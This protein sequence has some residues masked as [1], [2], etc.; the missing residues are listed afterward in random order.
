[1]Q[2]EPE[3]SP[4][5]CPLLGGAPSQRAISAIECS[6]LRLVEDLPSAALLFDD[7]NRVLYCNRAAKV[8]AQMLS[9]EG[10]AGNRL[11]LQDWHPHLPPEHA[12][13][14]CRERG[15]WSGEVVLD[16]PARPARVILL[17]VTALGPELSAPYGAAFRDVTV[18]AGRE[19]ELNLRNAELEIAMAKLGSAQ[20]QVLRTEKLASIGQLAA[21]VAH[22]INNPIAYVKSNLNTLQ[23][24][25]QRLLGALRGG[26][27]TARGGAGG[28]AIDIDEIAAD[29]RDL[30]AE[31][32]E[33]VERVC[34]IV[35]DL[36]DFSHQ[37]TGD[38]WV[39]ADIHAT[40]ESTLNV[41][42]NEIKYKAHV[43]KTFGDLPAIECLPSE[44]S[45]VFMNLL[46]NAAQAMESYG[47]ITLSTE[48][49]GDRVRVSIGDDGKGI[50]ADVL[51]RIFDP[52]FTTKS[53][54]EGTGLG[55]AISY[56]VV[57]KHHGTINVTSEPGQGTL[58]MIELPIQQ[59]RSRGTE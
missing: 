2:T 54:G 14:L 34:K 28:V 23:Q 57:A 17:H 58:F 8:L 29:V 16:L 49:L 6:I 21:G 42:W 27:A 15:F 32:R 25:L 19:Q 50:A 18:D 46:V 43:I 31:S 33:G 41:V 55:L 37:E 13:A 24:Y 20:E 52:F 45:Q 53:V 11:L 22:E 44:L 36:K 59:P 30:L 35:R 26:S 7:D 5:A 1:M 47:V 4:Q 3:K 12:M 48:S 40:L 38:N 10:G 9:P 56:G 51:P 39:L